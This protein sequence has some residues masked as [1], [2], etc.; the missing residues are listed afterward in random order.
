MTTDQQTPA[1]GDLLAR[2]GGNATAAGVTFQAG[3]GAIFAAQLLTE[4]SVD[5]RLRLGGA[6][7]RSIRFETEAPLDDI[8]VET[9]AGGWIFVQVKTALSLSESLDSEFGKTVEQIVRQ[10]RTCSIGNAERG[11]DRNLVFG[12]DRM[13]IA[14]GPNASGTITA[15]LA[16]ALASMQAPSAAALPQAQQQALDRLRA[17]CA[18]AWQKIVGAVPSAE[19]VN[20]ALRFVTILQLDLDGPDRVAAIETLAHV[21]ED[22]NAATG[23][24]AAIEQAC[25]SLMAMRRGTDAID[26]RLSL[27][28]SGLRL[29]FGA[30]LSARG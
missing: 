28:R 5:D 14:V 15:D 26:L 6:R 3:V 11:W 24:F 30:H 2:G 27:A 16:A 17:L 9:D 29:A 4:R 21:M 20:D 19:D 7:V 12:R 23:A 8:L 18:T 25:Q 22:A 10:W 1:D 13:L